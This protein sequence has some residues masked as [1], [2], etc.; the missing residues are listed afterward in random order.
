MQDDFGR[1]GEAPVLHIHDMCACLPMIS[2]APCD[3]A[4]GLPWRQ[5]RD[6]KAER[7]TVGVG[8]SATVDDQ[9]EFGTSGNTAKSPTAVVRWHCQNPKW[10]LAAPSKSV[11]FVTAIEDRL[12]DQ[13]RRYHLCRV[14]LPP[15]LSP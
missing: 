4:R 14:S 10:P 1:Q 5:R 11:E 2:R 12:S 3:R 9:A 7:Q 15:A 13:C 8:R 6:R